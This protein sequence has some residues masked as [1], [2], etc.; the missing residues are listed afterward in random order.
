M[1][2]TNVT[3][4]GIADNTIVTTSTA[5][6]FTPAPANCVNV[7][8]NGTASSTLGQLLTSDVLNVIG[9][10]QTQISPLATVPVKSTGTSLNIA[11]GAGVQPIVASSLNST[12]NC[13]VLSSAWDQAMSLG[14]STNKECSVV[15]GTSGSSGSSSGGFSFSNGV[16]GTSE[17]WQNGVAVPGAVFSNG[18]KSTGSSSAITCSLGASDNTTSY[19]Q[20]APAL[21]QMGGSLICSN[22]GKWTSGSMHT[23]LKGHDCA[24]SNHFAQHALTTASQPDMAT[25]AADEQSTNNWSSKWYKPLYNIHGEACL[26]KYVDLVDKNCYSDG[27]ASQKM[28]L[29]TH[30]HFMSQAVG[31]S[32]LKGAKT[33]HN[34]TSTNDKQY[35]AAC[36]KYKFDNQYSSDS[37]AFDAKSVTSNAVASSASLALIMAALI[38]LL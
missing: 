10:A 32:C 3:T 17:T 13:N 18:A 7:T 15:V 38:Y 20:V 29:G 23:D 31:A 26:S 25:T 4:S 37:D 19:D 9:T 16:Y 14:D 34:W 28:D 5:P 35:A 2:H 27:K 21:K 6:V 22:N 30:V 24:F 8:F 12:S 36:E 11:T 33:A 1:I